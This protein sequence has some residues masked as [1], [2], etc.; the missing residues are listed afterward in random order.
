MTTNVNRPTDVKFKENDVNHKLQLFGIWSAF[1]KGK[2]PS[3]SLPCLAACLC[4]WRDCIASWHF[5]TFFLARPWCWHH[6]TC[7][8]SKLM[9]HWTAL[10]PTSHSHLHLA[11]CQK[12]ASTSSMTC[13]KSLS[14]PSFCFFPRMTGIFYKNSSGRLKTSLVPMHHSQVH[15]WTRILLSSMAMKLLMDSEL[16]EHWSFPTDNFESSVSRTDHRK[17]QH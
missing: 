2:A 14:R 9:S 7:R 1:A 16:L 17:A 6:R 8:T 10:L 15:Q 11:S 13:A 4:F 5:C 3:V 12:K